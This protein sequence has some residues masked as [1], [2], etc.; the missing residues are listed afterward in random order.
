MPLLADF[1]HFTLQIVTSQ[2]LPPKLEALLTGFINFRF[3]LFS[4]WNFVI[5]FLLFAFLAEPKLN[6]GVLGFPCTGRGRPG[7]VPGRENPRCLESSSED[8]T[9]L[10]ECGLWKTFGRLLRRGW[11]SVPFCLTDDGIVFLS[12][13]LIPWGG[14]FFTSINAFRSSP[15]VFE[16]GEGSEKEKKKQI[17][18]STL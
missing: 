3:R 5:D 8:E 18:F 2:G 6:P 11:F 13:F 4:G 17:R 10:L 9:E 14:I 15:S 12:D 1:F 16:R 7:V